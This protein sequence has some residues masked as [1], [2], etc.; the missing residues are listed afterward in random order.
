MPPPHNLREGIKIWRNKENQELPFND[1]VVVVEFV[2]DVVVDV[3][4]DVVAVVVVVKVVVG[5]VV[6]DDVLVICV[7]TVVPEKK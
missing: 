1:K 2:V 3:L 7:V 6:Y 5:M 4:V